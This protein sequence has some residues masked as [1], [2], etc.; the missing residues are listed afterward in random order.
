MSRVSS[1]SPSFLSP[2]VM[3]TRMP[4]RMV[5]CK[6]WRGHGPRCDAM[7]MLAAMQTTPR[8]HHSLSHITI[9]ADAAYC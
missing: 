6:R 3:Q 8:Q 4:T 2:P 5:R 7:Q 9:T 1:L